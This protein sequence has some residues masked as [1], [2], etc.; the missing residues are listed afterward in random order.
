VFITRALLQALETQLGLPIK[1]EESI[2][3]PNGVELS[4]YQ[5]LP[6]RTLIRAQLQLL[7]LPTVVYTGHF[8]RGRGIDILFHLAESFPWAQFVWVGG[9]EGDL[10]PIRRKVKE[11][12]LSNVVVT[13]FVDN[14]TLP[15][16][17]SAADI[18]LMPYERTI[19]GSSGG[20]SADICSPMKL[21]EYMAAGRAIITSDLPVIR[22]VLND[23]NAAFCPPE[24]L[25][26]WADTLGGL[27]DHPEKREQLGR[28]ARRDSE[29]Y[30][31]GTRQNKILTKFSE[32]G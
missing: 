11:S 29:Q 1:E 17:Q 28:N 32:Q 5:G 12:R 10:H 2:I 31:L 6:S 15:L 27:I 23:E 26:A 19:A 22:E 24:N 7:E 3:A 14:Q 25:D 30:A 21:F 16:Y 20:N 13:G 8:Y 18:L 9:R 4:R